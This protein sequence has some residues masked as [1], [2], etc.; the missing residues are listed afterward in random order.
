MTA[1]GDS[2]ARESRAASL[3]RN[4]KRETLGSANDVWCGSHRQFSYHKTELNWRYRG[5]LVVNGQHLF[6]TL[7]RQ[8]GLGRGQTRV[9][10]S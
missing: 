1:D 6:S 4:K 2:S 10:T 7:K 5:M 3:I 8:V 9:S